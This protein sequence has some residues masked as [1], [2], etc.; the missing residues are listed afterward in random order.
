MRVSV[1][2]VATMA[3]GWLKRSGGQPWLLRSLRFGKVL[4]VRHWLDALYKSFGDT[5]NF[6]MRQ[7][8]LVNFLCNVLV[9]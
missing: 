6:K 4:Y 1:L 5:F 3:V 9:P 7:A 2:R 8:K